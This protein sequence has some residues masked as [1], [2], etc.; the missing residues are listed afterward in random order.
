[1][2]HSVLEKKDNVVLLDRSITSAQISI[3]CTKCIGNS[4]QWVSMLSFLLVN[5]QYVDVLWL[6]GF[7]V[8]LLDGIYNMAND[9]VLYS[10]Q[11]HCPFLFSTIYKGKRDNLLLKL[12]ISNSSFSNTFN[13]KIVFLGL[14][15]EHRNGSTFM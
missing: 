15:S 4:V 8:W 9:L 13:M 6:R 2:H 5:M 12:T 1:M 10:N 14:K 11:A 7:C 3:K